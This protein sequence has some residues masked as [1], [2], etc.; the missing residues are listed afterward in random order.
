MIKRYV[1]GFLF[2]NGEVALIEKKRPEWQKGKLNGI[3]G[4]IEQGETPLEAMR[5]EFNEEAG[6]FITEWEYYCTMHYPDA[7]VYCFRLFGE[8]KVITKTDETVSWYPI[9]FIPDTVI[10]NLH[11]LIPL[12]HYDDE[13][14]SQVSFKGG[15]Q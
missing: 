10:P 3:G 6:E 13:Y 1:I 4:H 9:E 11:W 15:S 2:R 14:L 7:I 12:A 5:R 8:H